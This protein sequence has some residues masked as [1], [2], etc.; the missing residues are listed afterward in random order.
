[1]D[2]FIRGPQIDEVN[3]YDYEMFYS[4]EYQYLNDEDFETVKHF[5][6]TVNEFDTL[7][8]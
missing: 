2:D 4:D 7:I 5:Y 1:M 3:W 8:K 6:E